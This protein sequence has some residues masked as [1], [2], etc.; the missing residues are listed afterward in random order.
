MTKKKILLIVLPIVTVVIIGIVIAVL[1]FTT[2]VFKS[3][4]ELFWKFMAQNSDITT[5]LIN[6]NYQT[7]T[8][9][10]E[11]NSYNSTGDLTFSLNQGESS[12]TA[13]NVATTARH[14]V[15]TGRT[16]A[17][18]T[19]K[20]GDLDI[21]NISYIKNE[22]STNGDIYAVKASEVV[23]IYVGFR[24]T[25][26]KELA[27][28]Y[29]ISTDQVPD[30]ID[31]NTYTDVLQLTDEQKSH[32]IET[33]LPII[34]NN[35]DSSGYVK[36]NQDVQID[37]ETYNANVYAVSI[38]GEQLKQIMLESLE[39]LKSDTE[40]MVLI[41]N[42]ASTL[43]L[44]VDY[45]DMTNLT[46]KINDLIDTIN[47]LNITNT[48]TIYVYENYDNTIRTVIDIEGFIEVTYDRVGSK[49]ILT[50][51]YTQ[52]SYEELINGTTDTQ[53]LNLVDDTTDTTTDTTAG[54]TIDN[55]TN[56]TIDYNSITFNNDIILETTEETTGE[57]TNYQTAEII[58]GEQNELTTETTTEENTTTEGET[59]DTNSAVAETTTGVVTTDESTTQTDN[60]TTSTEEITRLVITKNKT[61]DQTVSNNI[62][63]IPNI[64]SSYTNNASLT[65]EMSTV[66]DNTINNSYSLTIIANDETSSDTMTLSYTTTTTAAEQVEEIQELTDSNTV[67]A[68]NYGAEQF[69]AF[70]EEWF[71]AFETVLTDKLSSIGINVDNNISTEIQIEEQNEE[72]TETQQEE[73]SVADQ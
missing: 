35:I 18:A 27:A 68:N 55:T 15:S 50:I 4:E 6:D 64:N 49:Q 54:E 70:M 52:G 44:G 34:Q 7:Q 12:S 19:L 22:D 38:T 26:L 67:I 65:Y 66:S 43:N 56:T 33:Y 37:G 11:S 20:N 1:Y 5:I 16:Y 32:I 63:Y 8:E 30:S 58:N 10:K 73:E 46:M 60:T 23:D 51:D 21:F 69:T 62:T 24:N 13:F 2:D 9:F 14:D 53:E 57:N 36:T 25:A 17:D 29:N 3:E 39:T 45:T 72:N 31:I 40:T 42:K 59:T 71:E 28:K 48:T 47:N 61:T 41:S